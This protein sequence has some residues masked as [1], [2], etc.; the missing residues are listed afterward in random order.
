MKKIFA[1]AGAALIIASC[2]KE[3]NEAL[4]QDQRI[5]SYSQNELKGQLE[6]V[7]IDM[8]FING[9]TNALSYTLRAVA[10]PPII[11]GVNTNATSVTKVGNLVYVTW[12]TVNTSHG[13]AISV[14][15]VGTPGAISYQGRVDFIETDFHQGAVEGTSLYLVGQRDRNGGAY[16]DQ[17]PWWG[18]SIF[19]KLTLDGSGLLTTTYA[20]IPTSGFASNGLAAAGSNVYD[21]ITGDG[22]SRLYRVDGSTMTITDSSNL[23][24]GVFT[25]GEFIITDGSNVYA[26]D[27]DKSGTN[28]RL[29]SYTTGANLNAMNILAG[30][31]GVTAQSVPFSSTGVERN[32]MAIDASTNTYLAMGANGVIKV[33]SGGAVTQHYDAVGGTSQGVSVDETNARL[34]IAQGEQGLFVADLTDM[35]QVGYSPLIYSNSNYKDVTYAPSAT[36]GENWLFIADGEKGLLL[37]EED[38]I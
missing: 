7:D 5:R 11:N 23:A 1:L 35:S 3:T 24:T 17:L 12:H 10:E 9:K 29:I 14:Y 13:G 38:D 26:L 15:D 34:Y 19:G 30:S 16:D 20:E 25:D 6:Q 37:V 18:G 32:A 21:I 28:S 33:T 27:G 4:P 22:S 36:A 2:S 8:P 31:G